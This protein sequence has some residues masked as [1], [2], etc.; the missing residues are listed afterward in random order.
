MHEDL[1]EAEQ[2]VREVQSQIEVALTPPDVLTDAEGWSTHWSEE[3]LK[4]QEKVEQLRGL[5][6]EVLNHPVSHDRMWDETVRVSH[7]LPVDLRA[8]IEAAIGGQG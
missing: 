7:D 8:R 5:L 1:A 3:A 4:A 6:R 2:N